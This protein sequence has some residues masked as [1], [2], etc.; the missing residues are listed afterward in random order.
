MADLMWVL[1]RDV[2]LVY[3]CGMHA[4][5]SQSQR[6]LPIPK[7]AENTR[8]CGFKYPPTTIYSIF[9]V[10]RENLTFHGS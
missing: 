10:I 5:C 1:G 9:T 2:L 6:K 3:R 8:Y 4:F 7:P